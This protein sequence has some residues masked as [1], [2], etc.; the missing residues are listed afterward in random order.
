[1][2]VFGQPLV[3]V[4]GLSDH[5]MYCHCRAPGACK[6]GEQKTSGLGLL[7]KVFHPSSGWVL[8]EVYY[9]RPGCACI[10]HWGSARCKSESAGNNVSNG[11]G[12]V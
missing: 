2:R 5:P 12:V 11:D 1:M 10:G 9:C 7:S 6:V 3:N 4:A 8:A